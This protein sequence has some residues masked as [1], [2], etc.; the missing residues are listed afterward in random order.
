LVRVKSE[1]ILKEPKSETSKRTLE[2]PKELIQVL[3][4]HKTKQKEIYL[5][6]KGECKNEEN[7]VCTRNN[8]KLINPCTFSTVFS[9]FL[10][11]R[12][13]PDIRFHD[14]RHTN[15][16]FM[17]LSDTPMKVASGRL[18]HSTIA[19]TADLYTHVLQELDRDAA[20]KLNDVL[21]K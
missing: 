7:L 6:S 18:G 19:I 14:L 2:A 5:R 1:L 11:R 9:K 3:K 8:G 13:L 21:Y 15:A 16:T 20:D 4:E 10:K 17:L 12:N